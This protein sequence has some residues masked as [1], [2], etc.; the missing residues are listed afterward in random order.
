MRLGSFAYPFTIRQHQILRLSVCIASLL[1]GRSGV[2]CK[3]PTKYGYTHESLCQ[4]Q[5]EHAW[6]HTWEDVFSGNFRAKSGQW[7]PSSSGAHGDSSRQ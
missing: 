5:E 6:A 2:T 3:L 7:G 1:H 4:S